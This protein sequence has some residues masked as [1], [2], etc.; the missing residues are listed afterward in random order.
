M[1]P[2]GLAAYP[3]IQPGWMGASNSY[4]CVFVCVCVYFLCANFM[5]IVLYCIVLYTFSLYK[6][7]FCLRTHMYVA[8]VSYLLYCYV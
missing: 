2:C 5:C 4:V 8:L 7:G 3:F 1:P 6:I